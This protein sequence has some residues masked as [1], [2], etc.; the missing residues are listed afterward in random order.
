VSFFDDSIKRKMGK[1]MSAKFK[2]CFDTKNETAEAFLKY[3]QTDA[4]LRKSEHY[5][6]PNT[7]RKVFEGNSEHP[8]PADVYLCLVSIS[9]ISIAARMLLMYP[10]ICK[11]TASTIKQL[12]FPDLEH[13]K[14]LQLRHKQSLR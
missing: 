4:H 8:G 7:K 1:S 10:S 14:L 3:R 2:G 13:T 9:P 5:T 12:L 6:I 11:N